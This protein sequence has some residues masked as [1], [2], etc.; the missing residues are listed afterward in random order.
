MTTTTS[1]AEGVLREHAEYSKRERP[2]QSLGQ[3]T[4]TPPPTAVRNRG[5]PVRA[6]PMLGSLH[7]AY[8]RAA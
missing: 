3:A 5:G 2:H 8:Q 6:V 1:P 4:T 7:P